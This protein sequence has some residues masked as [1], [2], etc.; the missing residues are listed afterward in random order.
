MRETTNELKLFEMHEKNEEWFSHHFEEL[1]G[2]YEDKFIAIKQQDVLAADSKI[3]RLLLQLEKSGIDI[4]E[5]FITSLPPKG[6]AA[7]L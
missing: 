2:K 6:I 4:D 3:D 7:I 1:K 5:V